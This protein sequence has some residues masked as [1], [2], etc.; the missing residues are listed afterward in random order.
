MQWHKRDSCTHSFWHQVFYIYCTSL[1]LPPSNILYRA[2][3]KTTLCRKALE[4]GA[5]RGDSVQGFHALL[6]LLLILQNLLVSFCDFP[7]HESDLCS[8]SSVLFLF[9]CMCSLLAHTLPWFFSML[10]FVGAPPSQGL[11]ALFLQ[12]T[13]KWEEESNECIRFDFISA[14]VC[15]KTLQRLVPV[16][17]TSL[18]SSSTKITSVMFVESAWSSLV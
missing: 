4:S 6:P 11:V 1:L 7:V 8:E 17:K 18:R 5:V 16:I 13:K 9:R 14:Q 15:R 2:Q 3:Y 12:V 10:L